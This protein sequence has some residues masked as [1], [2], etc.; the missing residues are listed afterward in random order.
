M[1]SWKRSRASRLLET[2]LPD[3]RILSSAISKRMT[4]AMPR[5]N[6]SS[7]VEGFAELLANS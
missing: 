6:S 1:A 5:A 3:L 4:A 2:P 7:A